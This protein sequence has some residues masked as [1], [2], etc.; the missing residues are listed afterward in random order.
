MTEQ[1][2]KII[3][4]TIVE[5]MIN[6]VVDYEWQIDYGALHGF[7]C[8]SPAEIGA[9]NL[10]G[11]PPPGDSFWEMVER[12]GF[13]VTKYD[14]NEPKKVPRTSENLPDGASSERILVLSIGQVCSRSRCRQATCVPRF[15]GLDE[16]ERRRGS[17]HR[18]SL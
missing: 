18:A 14:R 3:R 4:S 1:Q 11:S 16:F 17:T 8:G 6:R 10:W 2:S 13:K 12:H 5:A 15:L 9:A 7:A